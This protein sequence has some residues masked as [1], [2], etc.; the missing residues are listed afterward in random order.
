[1]VADVSER[2]TN[3][4]P[5][6]A[7]LSA[8][9]KTLTIPLSAVTSRL[10]L[11]LAGGSDVL[12]VDY[13]GGAFPFALEFAGGTG[14]IDRLELIGGTFSAASIASTNATS[15]QLLLDPAGNEPARVL[16]YSGAE[17]LDLTRSASAAL[18]FQ[19]PPVSNAVVLEDDGGVG[20]GATRFRASNGTL[21]PVEFASP[22]NSLTLLRGTEADTL[23]VNEAPDL[24][25]GLTVG[26]APTPF[27]PITV[28]GSVA[29]AP[30][31]GI[32]LFTS[33]TLNLSTGNSDL[34]VLGSGALSL[35]SA[36][37][38]VLVAGSSLTT[39]DGPIL[40]EVNQQA[41][42]TAAGFAGI[43]VTGGSIQSLGSGSVTLK[44]APGSVGTNPSISLATGSV[45]GTVG[46]RME[47]VGDSLQLVGTS[48]SSVSGTVAVRPK[49]PGVAVNLGAAD[50][51]GILGLTDVELDL[52]SG[53]RLEI[54]STHSGT[55]TLGAAVTRPS[56]TALTLRGSAV[57]WTSA[58]S[59]DTVSGPLAV[60][61]SG[62]TVTW[63]QT[64]TVISAASVRF[65]GG[66]TFRPALTSAT[67]IR[68]LN[69]FGEVRLENVTLDLDNA[70]FSTVIGASYLLIAN[71][72]LDPV[73]GTFKDLPEGS[74]FAVGGSLF[75]ISYV[76]GTGNDVVLGAVAPRPEISVATAAGVELVDGQATPIDF[77]LT[78]V[79][80]PVVRSFVLRNR[81]SS[82]LTLS[83]STAPAGF[84]TLFVPASVPPG[85]SSVFQVRMN[86]AS[87]GTFAGRVVLNSDDADEAAF[88]FPV[89]GVA[90]TRPTQTVDLASVVVGEGRT[91][92]NGGLFEDLDGD[93]V[94]L[95]ASVGTLT[96]G[97][98]PG[99]LDTTT[100][101]AWR[102]TN[103]IKPLDA[104]G[105]NV[106]GTDGYT[107]WGIDRRVVD[108]APT[109][110][111]VAPVG[112]MQ[113]F[114]G[115]GGYRLIDNPA[116]P[117]GAQ[118][119]SGMLYTRSP[120]TNA[121]D[122]LTVTFTHA[123]R[124][125][126]GVLFDNAEFAVMSPLA[127]R[128]RRVTG[129]PFDTG[130]RAAGTSATR[131][132]SVDYEFFDIDAQPGDVFVLSGS[133]DPVHNVNGVAGV[134]FD[135]LSDSS[136]NLL[137]ASGGA[138]T[139][140][141]GTVDGP[142]ET[143]VTLTANDGISPPLVRTFQLVVT[144]VPPS[145]A[146]VASRT[147]TGLHAADVTLELTG[148]T[149]PSGADTAAGFRHSF[150]FNNDG[151][152]DSGDGTY[153]GGLAS[154]SA[155]V[156]PQHLA[157]GGLRTFK[158]R[159][160][161]KD[162]GSSDR[163]VVVD[164][165]APPI[166][167]TEWPSSTLTNSAILV[168]GV[169]AQSQ[170]TTLAFEYGTADDLAG[171]SESA[172]VD[173]GS[174]I[175][176]RELRATIAGLRP[177]TR[178]YYRARATNA[179]GVVRGEIR[180]FT[181]R[182]STPVV[183]ADE[184]TL[185]GGTPAIL[186]VLANDTDADGDPLV[187]TVVS[188]SANAAVS[189]A[190]GGAG[191]AYDPSDAFAGV[192]T[193]TYSVH[194][195]N[196]GRA[197]GTVTI[198]V[199]D[200]QAPVF[201]VC[202]PA[203][204]LDANASARA[205]LPNLVP[206]ATVTDN[207]GVTFLGQSPA[208]GTTVGLGAQVVTLT[209]R[210]AAGN[211]STCQAVVTVR[212]VTAPE[213]VARDNVSHALEWIQRHSSAGA[214]TDS[215]RQLAL[216][217]AGNTY[218]VGTGIGPSSNPDVV[219]IKYSPHGQV[220]WTRFYNG[221]GNRADDAAA[222]VVAPDGSPVITATVV[223]AGGTADLFAAKVD[224]ATGNLVW[225]FLRDGD[226]RGTDLAIDLAVDASGHVLLAGTTQANDTQGFDIVVFKLEGGTGVALW[227]RSLDGGNSDDLPS[228]LA[229]DAAGNVFLTG[230]TSGFSLDFL[231]AKLAAADGQVLWTRTYGSPSV[232]SGQGL[233]LA[234][235]AT[236]DVTVA[237]VT[238]TA[239]SFQD[240]T[241]LRYR[242]SDGTHLWT[243]RY[244][245]PGNHADV[246]LGLVVDASGEAF[247]TGHSADL[248]RVAEIAT[249]KIFGDNGTTSWRNRLGQEADGVDIGFALALDRDGTLL[250]AGSS[251]N[252]SGGVD[253]VV[254]KVDSAA[255]TNLW[256]HRLPNPGTGD[257]APRAIQ[258]DARGGILVTAESV[259]DGSGADILT[260]KLSQPGT[261]GVAPQSAVAGAG[262]QALVPDLAL[263][264]TATDA[265]GPLV[266]RQ[267]P[268]AGTAVGPGLWP[269]TLTVTDAAGNSTVTTTT[270]TVTDAVAPA[271]AAA[272]PDILV[273][274]SD[275]AGAVVFFDLP[276][277][278]DACSA[279]TVTADRLSGSR[280][281]VGTT[282]VTVTAVDAS[283]NRAMTTFRVTVNRPPTATP[284]TL[285]VV[286]NTNVTLTLSRL[287]GTV[288]DP[289]GDVVTVTGVSAA[290]RQG[291]RV[292][293]T[294]T[295]I[296]YTPPSGFVGGDGFSV[297]LSDG[298]CAQVEDP[299][300]VNVTAP[301][302][303]LEG[304]TFYPTG[305]R[306]EVARFK[307]YITREVWQSL[308]NGVTWRHLGT[309]G[310]IG[311]RTFYIYYTTPAA[312][313]Y[314]FL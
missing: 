41:P 136:P 73:V 79:G 295:N 183:V 6:G 9:D 80:T 296:T 62:G 260:Y 32:E 99:A 191:I 34:S 44:G 214:A 145:A 281:P 103:V 215:P 35:N 223:G 169:D 217:A 238:T 187:V 87:A 5:A 298:R 291:G 283:G 72:G 153:A 271:F 194:D 230:Q 152:W 165:V 23:V 130:Y 277:A 179:D 264:I 262:C 250:V 284:Y 269:L 13:S 51:A 213:L 272:A 226:G 14:T 170:P 216:D 167:T 129:V 43:T 45:L 8:G 119:L 89:A 244:N 185:A 102:S 168:A 144:N 248:R 258:V 106:Y 267:E 117:A 255:G 286:N 309:I 254:Q 11:N 313:H 290:S 39:V 101:G 312:G 121:T 247:V 241:L 66:D 19:L 59:I 274:A 111:A 10:V 302:G 186:D 261:N 265:N 162:G 288:T 173:A 116:N 311:N 135:T 33:G 124:V 16:S 299:I 222:V 68:S 208:A 178:Y 96:R 55:L 42:A 160:T 220:L 310:A 15:G 94:T 200:S 182:N 109:Y 137:A 54:G 147:N 83:G 123:V 209:A 92:V 61:A 36:R 305:A 307:R 236:G 156:P 98:A 297:F 120:G 224:A 190:P 285:N 263:L 181:T 154:V 163:T 172:G 125:R 282:V 26:T 37:D 141:L 171:A 294:G 175:G 75:T 70:G 22:T 12:G 279:V 257:A 303:D 192:D 38:V 18:T 138:W 40:V 88:D 108:A 29:P 47:L 3:S 139:W 82:T 256:V 203:R 30:N 50:A 242:G 69:V 63:A 53:P 64:G 65:T 225:S 100:G 4:V 25:S 93:A 229:L 90:N 104:D 7:V 228:D 218:V 180:M 308:D 132:K 56:T 289:D 268:A 219:L 306:F 49:T 78:A 127:M 233:A 85:G 202:A 304:A 131:D 122:F 293:L 196:G 245:G 259:V 251:E 237:G 249:V 142:S 84:Q 273:C 60:D 157:P 164:V 234:V 280:F 253:L 20:N 240:Y 28:A 193:L 177:H 243:G 232:L 205:V 107:F 210:D 126:M 52:L 118:V 211:S 134:F 252:A 105:D 81:G 76:G 275:A 128:L 287:L 201:S 174:G 227:T 155:T 221:A 206:Q 150:D 110:V 300:G 188:Q 91:A 67:A 24:K 71:D 74:L 48:V 199:P 314:R 176:M 95:S 77:G 133:N 166:V 270:F 266:Y 115:D 58:G 86:A 31:R 146:L 292:I 46:G 189:V 149:D 246:P 207:V 97:L 204:T 27:G 197:S 231:T 112:G 158:A 1:V 140:S 198:R 235:D 143:Q 239:A 184:A 159:I 21:T 276:V 148:A 2:F 195:G 212:D 113:Q 17:R 161:D 57:N 278:T 151:T 114:L 301:Q